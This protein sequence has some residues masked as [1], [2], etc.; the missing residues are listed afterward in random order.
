MSFVAGEEG[1]KRKIIAV[2]SS[3]GDLLGQYDLSGYLPEE[4]G[5]Y[6]HDWSTDGSRV[7]FIL[8]HKILDYLLFKNIVE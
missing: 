1:G 2:F 7:A 6:K 4:S 8:N 3:S 5:V